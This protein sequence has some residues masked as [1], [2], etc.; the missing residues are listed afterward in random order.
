LALLQVKDLCVQFQT[1]DGPLGAVD[2]V[3]F[4]VRA[5][6]TLGLVGESG[7]G[8]SVTALSL[9]RLLPERGTKIDGVA[10]FEGQDLLAL[11]DDEMRRIRGKAIAMIFQDP[12]SSL[13]PVLSVGR[14][15]SES[16]RA[17]QQ[18]SR[19]SAHKRA[20]ELLDM[21]GIPRA[22]E[23]A[24]E[25]PHEFSG[26][27]RQRVMIAMALSCRPKLVLADEITTALDVT[28][29]AQILDLLA[30]L[31]KEFDTAFLLITHDLGIVA[32]MTQRVNVMYAG[33]I[34]ES[35]TTIELFAN[36]RMP[37]TWGLL[38][39]MPRVDRD[40]VDRLVPIEGRPPDLTALPKGCRFAPRCRYRREICDT[41]PPELIPVPRASEAHGARCWGTQDT[42]GGGW[43]IDVDWRN[44][45]G[46]AGH[47][48]SDQVGRP[49]MVGAVDH[50][51]VSASD[52]A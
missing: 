25:Y 13:N 27:M 3:T 23:R 8:K 15:I 52:R 44:D 41:E 39:S 17:H 24:R 47:S 49:S 2:G 7:S 12:M 33:Q 18:V 4:D 48:E 28:I 31:T 6:E 19:A 32:G 38:R 1:L 26:G 35:A 36:P 37:Y 9:M 21:V 42:P 29:Q 5:G 43:L 22:A 46:V 11:S 51:H 50:D 30:S 10:Q 45:T 40:R 14:Q 34:V 20:V 16:V